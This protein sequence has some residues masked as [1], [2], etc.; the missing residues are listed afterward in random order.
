MS[1]TRIVR[2]IDALQDANCKSCQIKRDFGKAEAKL[3]KHC[4][5]ECAIGI[6]LRAL[7][8]KLVS[9]ARPR[10]KPS[11]MN[12]GDK[13]PGQKTTITSEEQSDLPDLR[14]EIE[15]LTERMKSA[16]AQALRN[17]TICDERQDEI[18]RLKAEHEQH[19]QLRRNAYEAHNAAQARL[20]ERIKQLEEQLDEAD[21]E[22]ALLLQT[23]ERAARPEPPTEAQ[24]MDQAIG[25]LTRVRKLIRLYAVGE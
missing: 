20:Q 14:A 8:K 22:K 19:A 21:R 16:Q 4:G 24:L 23:I 9:D 7:G 11:R 17:A 15:R 5:S 13:M 18:E 6:R 25:E 1:R 2:E 12:G 10:K 3:S